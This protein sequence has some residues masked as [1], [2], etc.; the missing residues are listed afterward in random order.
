MPGEPDPKTAPATL[1]VAPHGIEAWQTSEATH[2]SVRRLSLIM[3]ED[4]YK[5]YADQVLAITNHLS[6]DRGGTLESLEITQFI[7]DAGSTGEDPPPIGWVFR[8]VAHSLTSIW[9]DVPNEVGSGT[10]LDIFYSLP[11]LQESTIYAP[12]IRRSLYQGEINQGGPSMTGKLGLFHLDAGGDNFINQLLQNQPLGY[13]T[14]GLSHN[15]LIDSYNLLINACG[16]TLR[17]LAVHHIGKRASIPAKNTQLRT[18]LRGI[19]LQTGSRQYIR[20]QLLRA[21]RTHF[22]RGGNL[23]R[24]NHAYDHRRAIHSL[25]R[26]FREAPDF[27]QAHSRL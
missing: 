7:P 19:P 17:R 23:T 20:C 2:K 3:G 4:L 6:A 1:L 15:K 10:L 8:P 26:L 12:I 27:V 24:Q 18:M 11:R 25:L 21:F 13:H 16:D 9:L 22:R 14:I 5:W